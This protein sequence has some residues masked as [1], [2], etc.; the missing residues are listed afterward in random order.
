MNSN[1]GAIPKIP[2]LNKRLLFAAIMLIVYRL[3]VFVP[4]PGIDPE[5]IVKLF[6]QTTGT[7]F[8]I[9]NLFSGGALARASIFALGV[10]PYITSSII[11][12]LLV[13][14]FPTLEAIQ[15][16]GEAGRKKINQYSRYGTVI[17]CLI[18]GFMLAVTLEGGMGSGLTVV[19]D[20]GWMFRFTT[21]ITL[22]AG[23]LFIMWIGEQIS[24]RGIGN[25]ISLIIAASILVN[26]PGAFWNL[27]RL[28]D[29]G[30]MTVL[31]LFLLILF[32]ALVVGFIVFVERS[33]RK[34]PVQYPRRVVGRKVFGGQASHLPLKINTAGVIPP[35][36]ASSLLI[37]PATVLTFINVPFLR[38]ITDTLFQHGLF[39]NAIYAALIIFF[40]YFYTAVIYNPDDL[41][42][43]LRKNGGFV[44]G[45]RPGK[46]TS[47]YIDKILGRITFIGA[48]YVAAV[49]VLPTIL[50]R[51]PFN[52][53]FFFGG[54]SLLIVVGVTLDTVQQI[55][56]F[57][58]THSYEGFV[59]K[60]GM[61]GPRRYGV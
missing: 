39:Y 10:M 47:E 26:M 51:Q 1:I 44:P 28:I 42:D 5:Q 12:S 7:I 23:S 27:L 55:E 30:E 22:S 16:E 49:C 36:F 56:S 43:N 4:I 15:K 41:A 34:I 24:E 52:L 21:V 53:P 14:A 2:E 6:E 59:R 61:K 57:L 35:I 45:I 38:N 11:M 37:F 9:L 50:Q 54:T 19:K 17:I 29:T 40:A 25:G 33:Y 20:P 8:D 3:G 18:Q 60:R 48:I 46:K 32:M 31:G 58:I 13:K